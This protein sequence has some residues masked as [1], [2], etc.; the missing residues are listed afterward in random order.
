LNGT[1]IPLSN[2]QG[3]VSI[4]INVASFWGHTVTNYYEL[5]AL[6][7]RYGS[8]LQ[9]IAFPCPQFYNQEPSTDEE[10]LNNLQF[11]RPGNGFHPNFPLFSKLLVNGQTESQLYTWL[12]GK[13]PPTTPEILPLQYISWSPV[14]VSDITWNFEKFLISKTGIPYKRYNPSIDPIFLRDDIN[15]LLSQ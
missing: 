13:C 9:I 12:K 7:E 15:L 8:S 6:N 3:K 11:V 2:F 1:Q 4:V 5:N 10:I 14:G